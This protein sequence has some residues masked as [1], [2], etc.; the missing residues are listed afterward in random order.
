MQ[1]PFLQT[2]ESP[3]S[4]PRLVV[5]LV[6][7]AILIT[8]IVWF[9]GPATIAQVAASV[10]WTGFLW[11]M[12]LFMLTQFSRAV[13][14]WVAMR[15]DARPSF[16]RLFC[17]ASVHQLLNH[18]MPARL[19]EVGF[20]LLLK[21]F[22][23]VPAA[24]AVSLLLF[25]R[26]QEIFVLALI[27]ALAALTLVA[28]G[29]GSLQT[30]L[31]LLGLVVMAAVVALQ[32]SLRPI[33]RTLARIIRPRAASASHTSRVR[34]RASDFLG[35]V[36]AELAV[37]L[38][39]GQRVL[40]FALTVLVWISTFYFF[41]EVLRLGGIDLSYG[42]TVVGSALANLSHILP[43]NAFGSFGSL[44]A[45]WTFGFSMLGVDPKSALATGLVMHVLVLAFLGVLAAPGWLWLT[46]GKNNRATVK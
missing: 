33:L 46:L 41:H 18:L 13:R 42:E 20:P 31:K 15:V 3:T 22:T 11:L 37:R 34:G 40:F 4:R 7:S 10:G 8:F 9:A 26:L 19:G 29:P 39:V 12:L 27:F 14:L 6:A 43:I 2:V 36:D 24:S 38:S 17:I 44:E 45:G 25:V 21:R 5:A 32:A 23:S 35:R 30:P 28:G 16:G 1:T